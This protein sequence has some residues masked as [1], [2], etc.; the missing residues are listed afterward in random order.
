ML[1][2]AWI[3]STLLLLAPFVHTGCSDD[4]ETPPGD[5]GAGGGSTTD[6]SATSSASTGQ[7][8]L[9]TAEPFIAFRNQNHGVTMSLAV[10]DLDGDGEDDVI[11]GGRGLAAF[12]LDGLATN[13]P[14]WTVDWWDLGLPSTYGDVEWVWAVEVLEID[15]DG[16]PDVVITTGFNMLLAFSGADAA[17]LWEAELD[18]TFPTDIILFDGDDDG[19]RDLFVVG[20]P[21][22]FS[23]RTGETLWTSAVPKIIIRGEAAEIDGMPGD[24]IYVGLE[25]GSLD[26]GC[27]VPLGA[28]DGIVGLGGMD[29]P[30]T[31][32]ALRA[33]G[34]T[35]FSYEAGESLTGLAVADLDGDGRHEAVAAH[36]T[37]I[38]IIS[39]AGQLVSSISIPAEEIVTLVA[40]AR[41]GATPRVYATIRN[42]T[43]YRI[44]A[45]HPDG[46]LVW[47]QP[48][49]DIL[50]Y[51]IPLRIV[52]S[53]GRPAPL[54]LVGSGDWSSPS[55]GLVT[56]IDLD[57]AA[58]ERVAWTLEPGVPIQAIATIAVDGQDAVLI[59]GFSSVVNAV[60]FE[61]GA[62]IFDFISGELVTD[63]AS[64][65]VDGDGSADAV[66]ID[67]HGNVR[68]VGADGSELWASRLD[69]GREGFGTSVA[70]ADLDGDGRAEVIAGGATTDLLVDFGVIDVFSGTGERLGTM[71]VP[72]IVNDVAGGDLDG[73]G[74]LEVVAVDGLIFFGNE[75]CRVYAFDGDDFEQRFAT[76]FLTC[77]GSTIMTG[78]TDGS[79]GDEIVFAS[80]PGPGPGEAALLDGDGEVVWLIGPDAAPLENHVWAAIH[81]GQVFL[82]G[83]TASG[84]G[85]LTKRAPADGALV[86]QTFFDLR[87][88]ELEG[89]PTDLRSVVASAT[90]VADRDNDG[91][92]E[93]AAALMSNQ[94][95]LVNGATGEI[96]W[97]TSFD[98]TGIGLDQISSTVAYV[99]P[100]QG[101]DEL[102]VFG[103]ARGGNQYNLKILTLDLEGTVT[104][105]L[106]S[107][108]VFGASVSTAPDGS[109]VVYLG[110]GLDIWAIGFTAAE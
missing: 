20:T 58:S 92:G 1:S 96:A 99:P 41:L 69:V 103:Q 5:G 110:V 72:N 89:Q 63:V 105:E 95:A 7:P 71:H 60:D 13:E 9:A 26:P 108:D 21:H 80:S 57:E 16:V 32:W 42:G 38:D 59:G 2:R 34:S 97:H 75:P 6:A 10:A 47:S 4:D 18:G 68:C 74:E 55:S 86:W 56:A 3:P 25:N 44:D 50:G 104:G 12:R 88:E 61:T 94:A 107:N 106:P 83:D 37:A 66:K 101:L 29:F 45:Y 64:G 65:D 98:Y 79:A 49:G 39:P 40:A 15:D 35:I 24:E 76:P 82:G 36:A 52:S 62:P 19:V 90:F 8:D 33:D 27:D 14:L 11:H 54:L 81:D 73:D 53:P 70:V 51:P 78:D 67:D 93:L 30:P 87:T 102:L 100:Y 43:D 17:L 22:G 85:H 28:E 46:T 84:K 77:I 109:P 31:V 48:L 91:R 23:G